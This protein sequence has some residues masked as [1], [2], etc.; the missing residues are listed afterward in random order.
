M[1]RIVEGDLNGA[2]SD[3]DAA[4]SLGPKYAWLQTNGAVL[5]SREGNATEARRVRDELVQLSAREWV[6]PMAIA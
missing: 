2:R 1:L 6:S 3:L 5:A 4:G